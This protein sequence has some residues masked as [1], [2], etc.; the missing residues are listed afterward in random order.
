MRLLEKEQS[1][2]SFIVKTKP[3]A[4]LPAIS[5]QNDSFPLGFHNESISTDVQ[6]FSN[7]Y[8]LFALAAVTFFVIVLVFILVIAKKQTKRKI[9]KPYFLGNGSGS[10]KIFN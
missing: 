10:S 6:S 4:E 9:S 7:L 2:N 1:Q 5:A 8:W 3:A